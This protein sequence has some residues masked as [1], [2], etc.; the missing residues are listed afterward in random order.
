M[1]HPRSAN[2]PG[3]QPPSASPPLARHACYTD[4][5]LMKLD[6]LNRITVQDSNCRT[7]SLA[8][9]DLR[10]GSVLWPALHAAAK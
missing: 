10:P 4:R 5:A 7:A 2:A 9:V 8:C 3:G 1:D 6:R